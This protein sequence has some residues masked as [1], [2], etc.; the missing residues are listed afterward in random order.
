M[1]VVVKAREPILTEE[2][3]CK[4]RVDAVRSET[5]LALPDHR[6]E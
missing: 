4:A 3:R 2:G 1:K 6:G 5:A